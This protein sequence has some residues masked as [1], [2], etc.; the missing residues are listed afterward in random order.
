MTKPKWVVTSKSRHLKGRSTKDTAPELLL[1]RHLHGLGMRYQLNR[2]IAERFSADL[3]FPAEKL[4]IMVDGCFWH[5]CPEH[6]MREF[7]GPNGETW[8]TKLGGNRER[9]FRG[10]KVMED[11]G[12][13]VL[14]FWECGI[15]ES[16]DSV[17]RVVSETRGQIKSS[18]H[19]TGHG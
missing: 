7:N 10:T 2:T 16:V 8:R 18:N 5:G 1:R 12:W 9:D 3:T 6:G 13:H 4:V 19:T 14:R 17:G 11:A 15:K